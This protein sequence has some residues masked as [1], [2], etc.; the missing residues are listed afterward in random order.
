MRAYGDRRRPRRPGRLAAF[1]LTPALLGGAALLAVLDTESRS[2]EVA[3]A[4][5]AD[6]PFTITGRGNGH[7]RGMGQWGAFGY[8]QQGW[9]AERI[10]THYY[11]PEVTFGSVP[12]GMI[13]VRLIDR[14][15]KALEVY[16][17]A[18]AIVAGRRVEPGQAARLT[19]T[20]AG[21]AHVEVTAGCGGPVI[22][23]V[24]DPHP[25]VDPVVP[26]PDRPAAEL[27]TL[28]SGDRAYRGALGVATA[29]DGT[30]RTVDL[31]DREDYLLGVVP[32][33]TPADW[34]DQGGAEALRAQAIAARSYALA[35]DRYGYAQICDT[36]ACQMYGGA[37]VEDPRTTAAVRST[38]GT[39]LLQDG[40]PYRAEYSASTGGVNTTGVP[41][42]GDAA[43]PV[44]GWSRTR[45]AAEIGQAFEVGELRAV[46][47]TG[48]DPAGR[49]T[50][51]QVAGTGGTAEVDGE[52]A[53]GA[54]DLP[55][56]WFDIV[57][58]TAPPPVPTVPPPPPAP[59]PPPPP[60]AP[61]PPP[62]P[63]PAAPG[64][65]SEALVPVADPGLVR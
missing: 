7:G 54:L 8:A 45:T 15:D 56:D 6:A 48:R 26:G 11:G 16:S 53:R 23:A 4:V 58:G 43:A 64:P 37:G 49:V 3:P 9:P 14:D 12:P 65:P 59:E 51:L 61:E 36:Q 29:A 18:G 34:A 19:P 35:D 33:E 62:P 63:P 32:A 13:A 27:L 5:A 25:W 22:W 21:G 38:A 57:A 42:A 40:R 55:S 44:Q 60:P 39:V 47:V 50:G 46:Q 30:A 17:A 24:D 10:L 1:G 52:R 31:L 28:C 2:P 20:P 41:D